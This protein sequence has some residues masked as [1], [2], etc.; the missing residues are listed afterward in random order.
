MVALRRSTAGVKSE[1][2]IAGMS[3]TG[4]RRIADDSR[5]RRRRLVVLH[6]P[7]SAQSEAYRRL[8]TN[9][10]VLSVERGLRSLVVSSAVA[11]GQDGHCRQSRI[12]LAQAGYTVVLVDADL[13]APNLAVVLGLSQH[14]ALTDVLID[15]FPLSQALE[16]W[17]DGLPL[18][19]PASGPHLNRPTRASCSV[20]AIRHRATLAPQQFLIQRPRAVGDD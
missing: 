17:G 9:L 13:R 16:A 10:R 3:A 6:D 19:A 7:F 20:S 11:S 8:R 12:S 15:D 4:A 2:D 1:D 18:E 5:A 14:A